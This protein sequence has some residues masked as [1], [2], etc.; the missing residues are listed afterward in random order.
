MTFRP[1]TRLTAAL[2]VAAFLLWGGLYV[3]GARINTTHSIPLG[4]YWITNEPLSVG[5]YVMFCPPDSHAFR[6]AETRDYIGPGYCDTGTEQL[7]K[8]VLAAKGDTVTVTPQGVTVNGERLPHTA[9][10]EHDPAGR[11]MPDFHADHY[12]LQSG[13]ILVMGLASPL[14]Y[15]S[16]YFGPIPA[17]AVTSTII[18]ILTW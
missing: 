12:R 16:R 7:M 17:A 10:F 13:E 6:I 8:R 15:D 5:S 14:S 18:P 1:F 2:G 3:A 11:S 4:L 9:S